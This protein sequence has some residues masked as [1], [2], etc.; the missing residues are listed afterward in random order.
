MNAV[1]ALV[2]ALLLV[3]LG[4]ELSP[5]MPVAAQDAIRVESSTATPNF[6]NGITFDLSAVADRPIVKAEL[7]YAKAEVETLNLESADFTPADKVEVTLPVDFR[8][9]YVPPGIDITYRWRL[10]DDAGGVIETEPA[11]VSWTDSR[12]AWTE[13]STDQVS[14]HYYT[15]DEAY[16]R[17]ILDAAQS[18]VDRLQQTFGVE[19]SRPI[20]IWVYDS[21]DDFQGSQAPNSQE[22]IAGTAYPELQ[23]ILAVL[24]DGNEREVGRVVPHEISHQ[25]LYQATRNPFNVPATWLDEGLAVANQEN[26]NEAFSGVV[27]SAA[28]A[29][30]LFSIRS[31]TSDFPYDPA[32]A[33]LAYAES[34]SVVE[35]ILGRWGEDGT[36][37]IV[38]AYRDGLSHDDALKQAIGVDVDGLDALWKESLG[39]QGDRGVAGYASRG[40]Q[41][42]VVDLLAENAGSILLVSAVAISGGVMA[43]R[44]ISGRQSSESRLAA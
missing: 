30:R 33:T 28:E 34:Y 25:M 27:Q 42:D 21:K 11:S 2:C 40:Q 26:G 31:L 39:Y 24:P 38:A 8:S 1:R 35:F 14:V 29:G 23:V 4:I 20:R 15:G 44:R 7:L 3:A 12:F 37:A 13:V 18:T 41:G 6:P 10:T 9:A 19:R 32:D 5:M 17:R 16:A 36:A 22:W 43:V